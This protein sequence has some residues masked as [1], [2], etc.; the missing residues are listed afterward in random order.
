MTVDAR[1][2]PGPRA[3]DQPSYLRALLRQPQPVL[4]ELRDR[5]GAVCGLGAGPARIAIV[6]DPEAL[7]DLFATSTDSFR[8][9]HRFNALGFVV[10]A[11]SMIV[12]DGPDHRR[13]RSSVQA[14]FSRRR[15]DGWIPSIIERTDAMVDQLL[16]RSSAGPIDLCLA[17]RALVLDIVVR[18]LF[19]DRLAPRAAEIGERFQRPQDYLESPALRQVPHPV[20][21]TRRAAV[22]RDR[23]ALDAIIDG[24]IAHRRV[25]HV[26]DPTDVLAA[27]VSDGALS[28]AEVR[29]QAITLIGAGYDTTAAS[30]AWMLWRAVLTPGLWARVGAE[31][32]TV[33]GPIATTDADRTHLDRL[34]LAA[35]TMREALR[36]HPAGAI[37]PRQAVVDVVVGGYR[38]PKGTLILWSA[39]LAGRDSRAWVDP[40]AFDPDRFVDLDEARAQAADAAW[41]GGAPMHIAAR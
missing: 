5:F 9:G 6:G 24:E 16:D 32:D 10:G 37:S 28:D 21:F 33:L 2:L 39:H 27:L 8:W 12:S 13:R 3:R 19:G 38:I 23:R 4:D 26:D 41:V 14:A 20:P 25:N 1:R 29:D 36:L 40:L 34:D 18:N 11:G 7:V 17:G 30:L 31:A 22:R 35:R 15:L